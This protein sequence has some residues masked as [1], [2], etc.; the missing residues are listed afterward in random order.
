[1]AEYIQDDWKATPTLTVNIGVRFEYEGPNNERNQKANTYF[2]FNAT[3]PASAAAKAAYVRHRSYQLVA[4]PGQAPSTS[5]A[6]FASSA[7]PPLPSVVIRITRHRSSMSCRAQASPG[8]RS[9]ALYSAEASASSLTRSPR[10]I[11]PA[12]TADPPRLSCCRSRD[13]LRAQPRTPRPIQVSPSPAPTPTRSRTELRS[14]QEAL[15]A[16]PHS[17]ARQ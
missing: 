13:S 3:N 2:D 11:S 8:R 1:M 7:I 12:A 17:Q 5:T 6:A 10:S 9:P 14:H 16:C 4:A 15:S